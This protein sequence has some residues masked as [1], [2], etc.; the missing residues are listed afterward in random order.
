VKTRVFFSL[1]SFFQSFDAETL[2][3]HSKGKEPNELN[4][5]YTKIPKILP[6]FVVKETTNFV[7]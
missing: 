3:Y 4:S 7:E 6:I 5:H 2:V 1:I